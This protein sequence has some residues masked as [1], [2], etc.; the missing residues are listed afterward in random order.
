[1]E[2]DE[3]TGEVTVL[4][5]VA[6]HDVGCAINPQSVAGQIEGGCVQGLGFAM[7]EEFMLENGLVLT[8]SLADYLIPTAKDAPDIKS[9]ILESGEGLGYFGNRGIGEAPAAASAGAIANAIFDAVGVRVTELPITPERVF[10]AY[11]E[12]AGRH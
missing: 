4:K 12:N 11:K 10:Q 8:T 5:Y 1:M 6:C 7:T 3:E 9:I 2:V